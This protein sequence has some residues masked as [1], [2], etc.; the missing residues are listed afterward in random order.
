V[1]GSTSDDTLPVLNGTAAAGSNVNLYQDGA[2]LTSFT[3]GASQTSW[4]FQPTTPL[5]NGTHNFTATATVGSATSDPSATASVT[6]DPISWVFRLSMPSRQR[7]AL[8]RAADQRA[9][10]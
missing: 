3:L 4:S 7:S 8:H 2:L 9:V 1:K 5:S 10:H 6:I